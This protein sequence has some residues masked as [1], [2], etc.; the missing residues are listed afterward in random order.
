MDAIDRELA[1]PLRNGLGR[2]ESLLNAVGITIEID[3][4]IRRDIFELQQIRNCLS[5]RFGVVDSR[6]AKACP[7]LKKRVGERLEISRDDFV[8][9]V[10]ASGGLLLAL[11]Y[12]VANLMGLDLK[13]DVERL[14][15]KAHGDD[16]NIPT[17]ERRASGKRLAAEE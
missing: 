14:T 11:L 16:P 9:Y 6:L 15:S 12:S 3:D 17:K 8:R 2:F 7:W 5:H 10:N 1:G 4:N 13:G